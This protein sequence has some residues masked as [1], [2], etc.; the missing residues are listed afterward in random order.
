VGFD[1][2]R[3]KRMAPIGI[4]IGLAVIALS[5]FIFKVRGWDPLLELLAGEASF[6]IT[7]V[8]FAAP[9]IAT[10]FF[11]FFLLAIAR[12]F[13]AHAVAAKLEV[14]LARVGIITLIALPV[15]SISGSLLQHGL[16][17]KYGYHY[18]NLLSG[19]P[20]VWFND[21]V[22]NPEW[23]VRGKTHEWVREQ[24]AKAQNNSAN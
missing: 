21:W 13:R 22:K 7:S 15:F 10:F 17:P 12:M 5:G 16:L 11:F 6:R 20:T 14:T 18:C 2:E 1:T 19:N 8:A 9:L 24:A 4:A 23:C 3:A